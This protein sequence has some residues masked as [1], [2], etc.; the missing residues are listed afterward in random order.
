MPGELV[1]GV[2]ALERREQL[3]SRTPC[4]TRRRCRGRRTPVSR[5][6]L[7]DADL[8]P[9]GRDLARELPRVADEVVDQRRARARVGVRLAAWSGAIEL[10]ARAPGRRRRARAIGCAH[11]RSEVDALAAQLAARHARQ[12]EQRV[13]Q[14]AHPSGARADV[15]EAVAAL[16]VELVARSRRA[17][18]AR[19]RSS[20][21]SGARRSWATE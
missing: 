8:D 9:R 11:D 20:P 17:G 14:R 2:Q 6:A 5:R 1:R 4:R 7:V 12:R 3:R 16:G 10:D 15:V 18:S 21:R 19:S 13:D